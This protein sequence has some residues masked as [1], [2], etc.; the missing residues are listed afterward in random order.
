LPSQNRR[1][2]RCRLCLETLE[3]GLLR[4][5]RGVSPFEDVFFPIDSQCP[6]LILVVGMRRLHTRDGKEFKRQFGMPAMKIIAVAA[7]KRF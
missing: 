4:I 6:P 5:V 3:E 2:V 7:R 1:V